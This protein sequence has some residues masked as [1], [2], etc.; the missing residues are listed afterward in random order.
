M[1]GARGNNGQG[2]AGANWNVKIMV[3]EF[4]GVQE[5]QVVA[6]YTYP[7][8]MRKLWRETNGS[9]G[10]FVVSTNASWGIDG[11][12]PPTHRSGARSTTAWAPR[13]S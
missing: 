8:A 11:G 6:A 5:A 3:V 7:R 10:A 4:G 2:V 12:S 9:K 13:G 1:I